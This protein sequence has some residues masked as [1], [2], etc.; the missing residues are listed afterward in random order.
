MPFRIHRLN[1]RT[2][3]IIVPPNFLILDFLLPECTTIGPVFRRNFARVASLEKMRSRHLE[4]R[5]KEGRMFR[6][7]SRS[8]SSG[9]SSAREVLEAPRPPA[10]PF[11]PL[12]PSSDPPAGV[13]KLRYTT[14]R[15]EPG[16]P[17]SKETRPSIGAPPTR[18]AGSRTSSPTR[19]P[20]FIHHHLRYPNPPSPSTLMTHLRARTDLLTP[21]A[22]RALV[23]YSRRANDLRTAREVKGSLIA[24]RLVPLGGPRSMD[25]WPDPR[26]RKWY[27]QKPNGWALKAWAPLSSLGPG[28]TP[29]ELLGHLHHVILNATRQNLPP[30]LEEALQAMKDTERGEFEGDWA[31]NVL[32]LFLASLAPGRAPADLI[33]RFHRVHPSVKLSQKT[34]HLAFTFTLWPSRYCEPGTSDV[35]LVAG[36]VIGPPAPA[37]DAEHPVQAT[38]PCRDAATRSLQVIDQFYKEYGISPGRET[39]R[40]LARW[41]LQHDEPDFAQIAWLGWWAEYCR[42]RS[43]VRARQLG[44]LARE[45]ARLT[46]SPGSS[47]TR[48]PRIDIEADETAYPPDAKSRFQHLG[49][50]LRRWSIEVVTK[51]RDR[52]WIKRVE[53]PGDEARGGTWEWLGREGEAGEKEK[54]HMRWLRREEG[55]K[56]ALVRAERTSEGE[57]LESGE[58]QAK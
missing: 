1:Q 49:Y 23:Q 51:L 16:R 45:R 14:P 30:T 52:G 54:K 2:T 20:T 48:T 27:P 42:L 35:S 3:R 22:E 56:E 15:L 58:V 50:H 9:S 41:A 19:A 18:A 33:R 8:R 38:F 25:L 43:T 40:H 57:E 13:V 21:H 36:P 4:D 6:D 46:S 7:D 11:R 12:Y 29:S 37:K 44:R 26:K 47:P 24:T 34:L 5:T 28:Y 55:R 10:N 32:H 31:R 53:V 39:Y 17:P